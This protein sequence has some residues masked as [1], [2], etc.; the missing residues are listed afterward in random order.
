MDTKSIFDKH[1]MYMTLANAVLAS[2]ASITSLLGHNNTPEFFWALVAGTLVFVMEIVILLH[3]L[4]KMTLE[5]MVKK[6]IS[7]IKALTDV[8]CNND[9]CK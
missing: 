7:K 6:L 9:M 2:I 5:N 4:W 3:V 8:V 1:A